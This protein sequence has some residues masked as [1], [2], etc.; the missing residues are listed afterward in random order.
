MASENCLTQD[1][2]RTAVPDTIVDFCRQTQ[3]PVVKL[4]KDERH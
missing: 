3:Q 1:W 4:Q 2:N